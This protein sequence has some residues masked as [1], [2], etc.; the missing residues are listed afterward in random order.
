MLGIV[1]RKY[2]I[3]GQRDVDR[4]RGE[5]QGESLHR[6]GNVFGTRAVRLSCHSPA[7]ARPAERIFSS[8]R[9]QRLRLP[10]AG[11]HAEVS[12]MRA[13]PERW[14]SMP[15]ASRLSGSNRIRRRLS[16]SVVNRTAVDARGPCAPE[17]RRPRAGAAFPAREGSRRVRHRG[18]HSRR[19]EHKVPS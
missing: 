12:C 7:V 3:S 4:W 19:T 17:R 15:A 14:K 8:S 13:R 11:R 5:M 1:S 16:A 2:M 9:A 18:S 6:V 10:S